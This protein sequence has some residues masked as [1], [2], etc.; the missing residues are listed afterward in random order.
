MLGYPEVH[1]AEVWLK[2]KRVGPVKVLRKGKVGGVKTTG[3]GTAVF[4]T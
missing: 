2:I 3:G 4:C 1:T